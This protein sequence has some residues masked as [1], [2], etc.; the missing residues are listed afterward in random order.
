[1]L[2]HGTGYTAQ[3][4]VSAASSAGDPILLMLG[5]RKEGQ[6]GSASRKDLTNKVHLI[7]RLADVDQPL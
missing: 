6:A 1:M 3:P 2:P 7:S 4:Y 5:Y